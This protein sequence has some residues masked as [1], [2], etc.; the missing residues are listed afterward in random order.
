[1]TEYDYEELGLV[2]GLEIHQQLDTATKL[3]CDC[4]TTVREP[5]ESDRSFTRYLHPTKSE[6]GEIDEAALE[7]SMVDRE[8]EYLSYDTTCLVEEDDEPPHR[9]DREAMETTLEIAQLL[10]MAVVDQVNVMRK[11]VVDGSNTTGFQRSML[12]ANDGAIETS[13]GPVGIEDML[14]EEESCQRV[15]ETDD[16]VRFSLDRLGIPLVEIG[17]KPDISSPEQARE[18]AERIGMLL[19]STGKVKR[20]LGTIRQD[21]NVSIAEG[22]RIELK[23]VQ[24]LDDIDD[25]VRNEVRRQVE[26]LDIADELAEREASVGEPQDVTDVFA[27]T[28]S[29]VIEGALSSGGDVQAV[30]LEGFDGLVGREIQP[31]RRLGTELSD[32]AKRHGAGGIF[33][34]DELPA[35]GVTEAEVEAL[36]DAVGA[37]PEDAVA[38]VADDP[39]TA[40]LAIDAVAERA[41]TA[42]EGVPEET[43]DANED[44]T[45]RYLRPLPGAA[46]MYPETDVPPV[47]PDVTEVETPELLTEKVDRYESEFGLGSG[48]AEQV[49]YGQRWPLFEALVE[50]EGVDPTLAAGT[51]ESTL[52]ELRRDDVPVENLT[53]EHLR[54]AILLVDGGDV[55][56]EGIEDLLTALAEDPSLSAE[57]A[58]E[59]ED[60]GGVDESEVRDAVVEVVERHEDQVAEEGMGAFSALMGE[61]M[62]ALRGKADGDTVSDVLRSEIQKRA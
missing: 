22:A 58:V 12:V 45:S 2:A 23:G 24:S 14:L 7:E 55:P 35:Y 38:I 28:D 8:F 34:T 32:H 62:G 15:E 13:D 20:G 43:R 46:R 59:Q 42:L 6:L 36:R 53:D 18:A 4:P 25:L 17:T 30:L 37:G 48:L 1:M 26:L 57:A 29:G 56:R 47:E 31:D 21:V 44:A 52:T 33:H 61:C 9:V 51:L 10:D 5:E 49:A 39:E 19:R 11:I 27:D 54:G 50:G 60:L 40:E 41:E 3:F 16:G